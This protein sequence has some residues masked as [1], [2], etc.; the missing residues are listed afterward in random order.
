MKQLKNILIK[1]LFALFIFSAVNVQAQELDRAT[2]QELVN[3]KNFVFKVQTVSPMTGGARQITSDY[4]VRLLGDSLV[5]YLPY[6]GRAYSAAYGEGGGFNFTSTSFEYKTKA[7]KKGGWEISV[8][9][10]DTR[11]VRQMSFTISEN[12]YAS[13]LVTSNNRQPISYHG[14]ILK[15]K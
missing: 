13:L 14:Y 15:R 4:D 1:S 9:P 7:R 10:K 12:G 8:E 5:S 2:V 11:D 3:S 6:F